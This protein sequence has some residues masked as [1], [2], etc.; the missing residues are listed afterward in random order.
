MSLIL[1]C[2]FDDTITVG[3]VSTIV[4]LAF[5]RSDWSQME[6]DY[7]AGL[8]SVEQSNIR[9]F[10]QIH[11]ETGQIEELVARNVVVRDGFREVVEF[12]EGVG[13]RLAVVSSGLDIYIHPTLRKLGLDHLEMHSATAEVT[14][15]GIDVRYTDPS[16]APIDRGFK[17]SYVRHF[18][19]EAHTVIYV[20][21]GLSDVSAAAAAD[22]VIARSTLESRRRSERL[23]YLPFSDFRDVLSHV[24][25][26]HAGW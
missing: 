19:S 4:R 9:Q 13:I 20:G 26:I 15:S 2:D 11:V 25:R 16:G 23:P 7:H 3:N 18:K 1:Q 14:P 22:F 10:A 8:Y 21:D 24:Q 17:D 5:A 6:R 12:C